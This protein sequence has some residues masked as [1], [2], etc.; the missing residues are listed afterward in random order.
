MSDK[1]DEHMKTNL[2][3]GLSRGD[4]MPSKLFKF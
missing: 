2:T 1:R 4:V 3:M